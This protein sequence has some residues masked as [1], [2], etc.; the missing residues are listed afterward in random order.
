MPPRSKVLDLP[1]ELRTDLNRRLVG[2][3]FKDYA[4]LTD[5]LKSQGYQI[6]K[7]SLQRYGADLQAN[8]EQALADVKRTTDIARAMTADDQ[9][10]E[11]SLID[12]TTRIV[13]EQLLRITIALRQAEHDP[14]TLSKP[15]SEIATSLAKLGQMGINQKK[16]ADE[17]RTK[18]EAA[19]ASVE[20][21]AR[22]GG[23]TQK[24]VDEIRREILG[25]AK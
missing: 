6:S 25:I 9:D 16:W 17:V 7:S 11:G 23:M 14:L 10:R 4:Q 13:Q 24:A 3:G 18:A 5:Y 15:M 1:E 8:M 19:A 20:K 12:A 22:K 21:I 2:G